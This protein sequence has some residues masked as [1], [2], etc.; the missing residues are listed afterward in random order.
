M[1][2]NEILSAKVYVCWRLCCICLLIEKYM[3]WQQ[4]V[5]S[6]FPGLS[7][8][9][10]LSRMA[11]PD[12]RSTVCPLWGPRQVWIK[13]V[14]WVSDTTG[15]GNTWSAGPQTQ[16]WCP[17]PRA[18]LVWGS[19]LSTTETSHMILCS[20]QPLALHFG[21]FRFPDIGRILIRCEQRGPTR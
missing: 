15:E 12:L 11:T 9:P 1:T 16:Q 17:K 13:T 21:Y 14:T 10:S 8:S 18:I 5:W 20:N 4:F 6:L 3:K 7:V 19:V 2:I